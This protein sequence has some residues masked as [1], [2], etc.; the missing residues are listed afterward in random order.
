MTRLLFV[1]G[2]RPEAIKLAPLI[3]RFREEETFDVRVCVTAQHREML[4]QVLSTFDITPHID[5]DLMRPNQSLTEV[6]TAVLS[7]IGQ[8]LD[9]ER[10][11]WVFVQGDTTT[12]FA[13]SLAAFYAKTD[14]AHVEAGL[15]TGDRYSP[16]PEEMNR[17]LAGRLAR[18]HFAPNERARENLLREGV[19]AE[20][21]HVTGNTV[22]DALL[23]VRERVRGGDGPFPFLDPSRRLVLVTGHRRENFG[24]GLESVCRGLARI[25]REHDDVE[26][27]YPV[28]LNPN[29]REPVAR[30]LAGPNVHLVEPVDYESMVW[31]MD[32]A[33]LIVTDSGGIQEEAPSLGKPVLVTRNTTERPEAIEAGAA[34]LVGTD[35]RRLFDEAH[36]LLTNAERYAEMAQVR[37]VF[38]DGHAGERIVAVMRALHAAP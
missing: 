24:P 6:T 17:L 32:R 37:H 8:V 3:E 12:A 20:R 18:L 19:A 11:H 28:H 9:V 10:P 21:V 34:I 2:T 30:I 22:I 14:V 23:E 33:Y 27:L 1:F 25:A 36:A 26:L 35:E 13:A 16:W 31:L 15:R 5:L 4:D 7:G 29:V 38:G